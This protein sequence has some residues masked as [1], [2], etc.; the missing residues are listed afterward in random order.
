[1]SAAPP[2]ALR[3]VETVLFDVD[4]TLVDTFRLYL[5][6]YRRALRPVLGYAPGDAE[7][8]A[9][10]PAAERRFLLDW[11]GPERVA[12]CH[13]EMCRHYE[14]LHRTHGEGMYDGVREMLAHL[15]SAG[16]RLGVV[17]GKG[18][19]AWEITAR[20]LDLGPFEV[21]VTEDDAEHPKP[22]P[23]GLLVALAALGVSP[24]A[25]AYVGDSPGDL[26]AARAAGVRAGA[27]LWPKTDPEDRERFLAHLRA[28]PPAW[29]W[30]RPAELS[31]TFAP[32]C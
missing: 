27:A 17:T 22:H 18:R 32:W 4:G 31:R 16:L 1:M 29:A 26:A 7:I 8:L 25:A 21:V 6:S 28:H 11:V 13:A 10:D 19:A 14:A 30:E 24:A 5:E 15:R 2:G 20:H 9:R 3:P 12:D 23:G